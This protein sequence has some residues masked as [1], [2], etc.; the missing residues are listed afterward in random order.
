MVAVN[1]CGISS[2][3]VVTI[4]VSLSTVKFC[5]RLVDIPDSIVSKVTWVAPVKPLPVISTGHSRG[6]EVGEK[7]VIVRLAA[8][9]CCVTNNVTTT[10]STAVSSVTLF[11]ALPHDATVGWTLV[12]CLSNTL[13]CDDRWDR[14]RAWLR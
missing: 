3:T 5:A 8:A 4:A 7:L 6:A 10:V 12:H 2:G 9:A 1:G 11:I 14:V 13:T